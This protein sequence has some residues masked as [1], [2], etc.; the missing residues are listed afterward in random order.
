MSYNNTAHYVAETIIKNRLDVL[1][2]PIVG[3]NH[4]RTADN[5]DK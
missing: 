3:I 5:P 4:D 2:K 1:P